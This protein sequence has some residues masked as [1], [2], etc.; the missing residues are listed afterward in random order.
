MPVA[1]ELHG[2]YWSRSTEVRLTPTR[3]MGALVELL[4]PGHYGSLPG[5]LVTAKKSI[6]KWS[7]VSLLRNLHRTF[8]GGV[9]PRLVE[10]GASSP[11]TEHLSKTI[12]TRLS[13]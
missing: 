4:D 1:N 10:V 2:L 8:T 9:S 13:R 5:R 12:R 11:H 7:Q 3:R 6:R